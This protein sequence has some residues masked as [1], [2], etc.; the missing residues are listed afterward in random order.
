MNGCYHNKQF[1]FDCINCKKIYCCDCIT[2]NV[3]GIYI[4]YYCEKP[5]LI[6]RL[7]KFLYII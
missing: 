3:E 4:C 5:T 7:L 1:D 2:V 6:Q